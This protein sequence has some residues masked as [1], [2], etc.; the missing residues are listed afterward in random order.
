MDRTLF[1]EDFPYA[2]SVGFE[3]LDQ[4][5]PE[6]AASLPAGI[7]LTPEYV[8][9]AGVFDRKVDGLRA[10]ESQ[11]GHLFQAGSSV[12]DAMRAYSTHVGELGGVGPSERYWRVTSIR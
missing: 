9:I 7:R 3:Q 5:D 11:I 12:G 4:L 1:F 8:D 2:Q 6:V 10:Y